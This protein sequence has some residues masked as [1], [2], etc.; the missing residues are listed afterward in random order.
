[1]LPVCN[2][3]WRD[4]L[5]A[6]AALLVLA[7]D[8]VGSRSV[9]DAPRYRV[10]DLGVVAPGT[11]TVLSVNEDGVVAV[12]EPG[13]RGLPRAFLW[14]DGKRTELPLPSGYQVSV[15][16]AIAGDRCVGFVADAADPRRRR[17]VVW[18]GGAV[19]EV[20][21][22]GA[23]RSMARAISSLGAVAGEAQTAGP[24]GAT[25]GFVAQGDRVTDIGLL[26][27]GN[28]SSASGVNG[29]GQVVGGANVISD[30]KSHAIL[31][32]NGILRDLGL[33]PGGT[34]SQAR[35]INDK[36]VIV[37]WSDTND[38]LH[39]FLYRDGKMQD[40]G[41]LGD[42]PSSAWDINSRSQVVGGSAVN[43][44]IFHAFLWQEG[45]MTDLN[46]LL[47][48][49]S[50]WTLRMAQGINERGQIVGI[51]RYREQQH[52]FLLTPEGSP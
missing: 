9:G 37:G 25:H 12:T 44:R 52:G 4:V 11:D 17:A 19:R 6:L 50:G 42:A 36:G 14:N 2:L 15:A 29:R 22:P 30:G 24:D 40:L 1:M 45:K 41:T 13:P 46:T 49:K 10:L 47:P 31:Y 43:E 3:S 20:A 28:F 27:K 48:P 32:E 26:E 21:T 8:A 23:G 35:A 34:R 38:G 16:A 51:G 5:R 18:E 7:G 39:P 33:L